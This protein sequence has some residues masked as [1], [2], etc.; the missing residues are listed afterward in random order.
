MHF[1][2]AKV[3]KDL[4]LFSQKRK[5]MR[6]FFAIP[7]P[8]IATHSNN[9]YTLTPW[10][11]PLCCSC[12]DQNPGI[13]HMR[14]PSVCKG[15][16]WRSICWT[17]KWL[18]KTEPAGHS[19]PLP[20]SRHCSRSPHEV[21]PSVD[22]VS[23]RL[24][25]SRYCGPSTASWRASCRT[26]EGTTLQVVEKARGGVP[27]IGMHLI[28]LSIQIYGT[29]QIDDGLWGWKNFPLVLAHIYP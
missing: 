7:W 15:P 12:A 5:G 11:R 18:G 25:P 2:N 6:K 19:C 17:C 3:S 8:H 22:H 23:L 1:Q 20:S 13:R 4:F 27:V 16:L 21:R 28:P 26:T 24:W 10:I 14:W 29:Q 9:T